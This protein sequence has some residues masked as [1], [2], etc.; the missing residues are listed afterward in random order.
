MGTMIEW[1]EW[2][3]QQQNDKNGDKGQWGWW[4]QWEGWQ[5]VGKHAKGCWKNIHNWCEE[6]S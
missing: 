1:W 5:G 6:E 4:G 2:M 3:E